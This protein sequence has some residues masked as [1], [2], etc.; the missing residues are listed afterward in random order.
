MQTTRAGSSDRAPACRR[1]WN[2]GW[3]RRRCSTGANDKSTRMM[4]PNTTIDRPGRAR[5]YCVSL[6]EAGRPGLLVLTSQLEQPRRDK[7][8]GASRCGIPN[9]GAV[10]LG[11]RGP[12]GR[13]S[14]RRR[15]WV[16]RATDDRRPGRGGWSA[17][18]Q[19]ASGAG[20]LDRCR[21]VGTPMPRPAQ[22]AVIEG[23]NDLHPGFRRRLVDDRPGCDEHRHSV[24][25]TEG[26]V[27]RIGRDQR[28]LDVLQT[29]LIGRRLIVHRQAATRSCA[30]LDPRRAVTT[31]ASVND[32]SVNSQRHIQQ[33]HPDTMPRTPERSPGTR[34]Y[35]SIRD[36]R[37]ALTDVACSLLAGSRPGLTSGAE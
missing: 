11:R 13:G 26:D 15:T 4:P 16:H 34:L 21:T 35:V 2:V 28:M 9:R 25:L 12:A 32:A 7:A 20:L 6:G 37:G 30:N 18:S 1:R 31:L 29:E 23:R 36:P 17:R 22:L 5:L 10:D 27:Q 33:A 14:G 19:A 3:P 24:P 8:T